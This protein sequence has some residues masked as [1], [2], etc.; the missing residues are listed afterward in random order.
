MKHR[1]VGIIGAMPEEINGILELISGKEVFIIGNR[2]YHT[3]NINGVS[4]VA[5]FSK[6]GKVAAAITADCLINHFDVT[7]I[8]FVGVA[9]A[10]S[11]R[12]SVGDIVIAEKLVQHDMDARPL[13]KQFEIP[14]L[15]IQY[16]E[17][18]KD[19]FQKMNVAIALFIKNI[20]SLHTEQRKGLDEFKITT[21]GVFTGLIGSGDRFVADNSS[22]AEI[23]KLLP[24]I[25]CVEMEGAAMAQ[26]CFLYGVPFIVVRTISD[27]ANDSSH[28]DFPLFVK[29][30][31]GLYGKEIVRSFFQ[32]Q[33]EHTHL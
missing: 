24:D 33:N 14:L 18:D 7:E 20:P 12:L 1:S 29:D 3:G 2:E 16:F 26:V 13:I 32:I 28:V 8:I 6:W 23:K 22:K 10:I 17:S 21:P 11:D 31:A 27:A 19:L 4:V 15:G 30:V 5:V 9:G 25:L